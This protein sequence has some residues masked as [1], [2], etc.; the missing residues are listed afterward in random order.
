VICST[1]RRYLHIQRLHGSFV[2]DAEVQRV[3]DF[4]KKQGK[5]V[6]EKS[7]MEMK[8]TDERDGA[9]EDEELDDRWEDAL[10]AWLRP[11]RPPYR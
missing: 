3:V 5:P 9:A 11:A 4:L 10:R 8:D 2:S 7:I 1:C 6:Y